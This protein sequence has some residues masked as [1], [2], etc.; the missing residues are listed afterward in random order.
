VPAGRAAAIRIT[1]EADGSAAVEG[2]DRYA[3]HTAGVIRGA[4]ERFDAAARRRLF[5]QSV[6][7]SFRGGALE[8]LELRGADDRE[9]EL[10][11]AWRARVPGFARHDRG[12][13]VVEA[14]ILPVQLAES[15]VRLAERTLPLLV[16]PQEPLTQRVELAF[17]EGFA[18]QPAAGVVLA[19]AW[20]RFERT[21]RLEGRVLIREE[22]V[23]IPRSRVP[24]DGYP[25]FARFVTAI[26]AAQGVPL[27]VGGARA[28]PGVSPDL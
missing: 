1:V 15:F 13:L 22:R 21:E 11:V 18:P 4:L 24:P 20:G 9:A 2:T 16:P 19:S 23:E 7:A 10:V 5:E 3:G 26:D 6:A 28:N 8:S 12:A 25:E 17:P 27:R 14:P